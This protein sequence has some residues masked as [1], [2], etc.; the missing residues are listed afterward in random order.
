MSHPWRIETELQ[1]MAGAD[2]F[3]EAC[4]RLGLVTSGAA[5]EYRLVVDSDWHRSGAETYSFVFS[6]VREGVRSSFYLKACTALSFGSSVGTVLDEWVG[7]R[8]LVSDAGVSTPCLYGVAK[9]CLLEE[10][11]PYLLAEVLNDSRG[12][13]RADLLRQLAHY[14]GVLSVNGF[15]SLDAFSDLRSR[16]ED[17]VAI[18][19]GEDLGPSRMTDRRRATW[20]SDALDYCA[21]AGVRLSDSDRRWMLAAF[22]QAESGGPNYRRNG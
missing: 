20:L 8:K 19:F 14:S 6:L 17:L 3:D 1:D 10:A 18:D 12:E 22:E 13:C 5:S 11:V 21:S 15:V 7:R 4:V 9:A 16:G 2:S